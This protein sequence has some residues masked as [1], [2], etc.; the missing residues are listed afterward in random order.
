MSGAFASD[1]H[2][3]SKF[4]RLGLNDFLLNFNVN[5]LEISIL[6]FWNIEKLLKFLSFLAK[7]EQIEVKNFSKKFLI[8]E[9]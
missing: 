3:R 6:V 7:I 9:K 5:T 4:K 8:L 2:K 1:N